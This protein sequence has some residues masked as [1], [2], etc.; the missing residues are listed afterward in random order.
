MTINDSPLTVPDDERL[1]DLFTIFRGIPRRC[2]RALFGEEVLERQT[3]NAA[4]DEIQSITEFAEASSG[5][6]PFKKASSHVL[7]RVEPTDGWW[8]NPVT[9]LLSEYVANLVYERIKLHQTMTIRSSIDHLLRTPQARGWAGNLFEK[10]IHRRFRRGITFHPEAMDENSLPLEIKIDP[11]RSEA[12]GYF[13]T[14]SVRKEARSRKVAIDFLNQ[15]LVPLSSTAETIDSVY[16]SKD[17]TVLFQITVSA[18][19]DLNLKGISELTDELP[20]QA[21]QRI[22][23]VFV[24]PDHDTSLKPY[25]RQR[26]AVPTGKSDVTNAKGY[27][28]YVYYADLDEF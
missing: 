6:L 15:Y 8:G 5:P 18:S 28:Q 25:K 17:V 20:F 19:H 23:I 1:L 27:H 12:D 3:I 22:C 10:A 9:E 26:I 7:V 14:L 21:K 11:A 13:H 4:I 16:I 24:L 2:F